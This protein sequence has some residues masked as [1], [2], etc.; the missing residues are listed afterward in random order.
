[1]PVLNY[2]FAALAA[3]AAGMINA[4]AGGGTLIT[5]PVLLSI[6]IPAV[7]ANVTNTVALSPGFLG[8]TLAQ[9]KDLIGQRRRLWISLPASI[10][11][12]LVG[13]I[14]LLKTGEKLFTQLVPFL[15]LLA[16]ILLAFQNLVRKWLLQRR[17]SGS[18]YVTSDV[19]IFFIVFGITIYGGYF[20]AGMSVIVL[21]I[22]GLIMNDNL[23][24][25]NA[26]KQA[27]ALVTNVTAALF[28]VFS[29]K[30][31]WLVALVMAAGAL[32]G[33]SLGGRLANR[34]KPDTLRVIVVTL[35]FILGAFYL[36]KTYFL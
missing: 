9:S 7:S 11:G 1:M 32:I 16:S 18:Q 6:G 17:Q 3:V 29:G 13:G 22:L 36:V 25:L 12:G 30:V 10:L 5:F 4:L 31:F 15:I 23:V 2:V 34:V 19:L 24:R 26:V 14:L 21:A 27:I 33:G 28:F 35:G 8:G 20:G